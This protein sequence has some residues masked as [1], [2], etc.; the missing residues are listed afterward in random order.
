MVFYDSVN[1]TGIVSDV[2]FLLFGTSDDRTADYPLV[3]I[4]RNVNR[5]YDN[6]VTKILRADKRWEWDDTN[7]TDLPIAGIDLVASQEGYGVTA[8]TFLK[9]KRI[10]AKDQDGNAIPL[11]PFDLDQIPH[12]GDNEFLNTAGTP[13]YYRIQGSSVFLY[14]KPSYASTGGLRVFY[15]RNVTYFTASS[16]DTVPGF[17][18]NFHRLLSLGAAYDYAIANGLNVKAATFQGMMNEL[19]AEMIEFYAQ[20]LN[21]KES[22]STRKQDY[23]QI[24]MTNQG[25]VSPYR[26]TKG[27][28]I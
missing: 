22:F 20:R 7:K 21:Q 11:R 24:A 27:F 5:H 6:V 23:G 18:E 16:T 9:I 12:I 4:A 8:A 25:N 14:P 28:Y 15:Q 3:D 1:K 26:N 2:F 17:A 10:D 19:F 13:R